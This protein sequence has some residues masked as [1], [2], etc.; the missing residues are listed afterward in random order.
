MQ[1][2]LAGWTQFLSGDSVGV[3]STAQ[4][5]LT[6]LEVGENNHDIKANLDTLRAL[7]NKDGGWPVRRALIGHS[8]RSITESTVYCLRALTRS[9]ADVQDSTII[10]GIEWLERAQRSDGGWGSIAGPQRARVYPTAFAAYYLATVTGISSAVAQ[11][12]NWLREAQN[13]DGGGGPLSAQNSEVTASTAL[14]TAHAL[15]ALMKLGMPA[16]SP[17]IESGLA[18]L[19]SVA[20][21]LDQEPWPSTSEVETVDTDA[22]LDF[23]HFTTPWVICALLE[24]GASVADPTVTTATHWLLSAQHS[25]GYWS[26]SLAPGQTPIWATY[27]AIHAIRQIRDS[28]LAR[29]PDLFEGD[30]KSIELDFAWGKYFEVADRFHAETVRVRPNSNIWM[31]A[32][33]AVLTF[34]I[35]LILF[36]KTSLASA[37][38]PV[39]KVIGSALLGLVPGFGPFV[40]QLILDKISTRDRTDS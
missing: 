17:Q 2:G 32:W 12:S 22:A 25:L 8:E 26:S 38:S 21:S 31:Y 14:H 9:G 16:S 36:Y 4:G 15:L 19:R 33:N 23:R 40:Y 3:L 34:V 13:A 11:A 10:R 28:A 24:S 29:L 20:L 5:I 7:Q 30:A 18:Y 27:D 37:L 35:F 39:E 1:D 6:F